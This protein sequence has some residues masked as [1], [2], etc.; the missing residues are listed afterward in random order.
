M[1][2][3][4][5]RGSKPVSMPDGS[6]RSFIQDGDEVVMTGRAG[7]GERAIGFGECRARLLPATG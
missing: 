7:E 5:W 3:I 1:L 6:T 4:A 2:E